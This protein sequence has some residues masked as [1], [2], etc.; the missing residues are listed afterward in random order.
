MGGHQ[1][2]S[3]PRQPALVT[4]QAQP[5]EGIDDGSSPEDLFKKAK[6][7]VIEGNRE[8]QIGKWERA[9]A[10]YLEGLACLICLFNIDKE[11]YPARIE[12][13]TVQKIT[14]YADKII[15]YL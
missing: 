8:F 3:Y 11:G 7:L 15:E 2:K 9:E 10:S 6:R 1:S 14:K 13:V 12:E 4:A 5:E